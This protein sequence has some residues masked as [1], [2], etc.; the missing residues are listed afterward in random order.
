MEENIHIIYIMGYGRSGSTFLDILFNNHSKIVS[1][2]ALFNFYEWDIRGET[3]A[4][5]NKPFGECEFW[6]KVKTEYYQK[7][8]EKD[9][10]KLLDLDLS[11]ESLKGLSP[12]LQNKLPNSMVKAYSTSVTA[13]FEAISYNSQKKIIVDSSKSAPRAVIGRAYALQKFTP[14]NIKTIHLIRDGRGV[15]WSAMKKSGSPERK[16]N[17]SLKSII[18][19]KTLVNWMFTNTLTLF[20]SRYLNGDSVLLIRYEDLVLTPQAA[21]QQ[22]GGFLG[23]DMTE[24]IQKIESKAPLDVGYN[25]GGNRLR[26]EKGINLKPD[27]EW[28]QKLPRLY[29]LIFWL[30]AWPLARRFGYKFVW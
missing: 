14:F 26:F 3:C 7:M 24:V 21:L 2:G 13:L 15:M 8:E 29:K 20:V 25:L 23:Y 12:L 4:H 19:I 11:V 5:C 10:E 9:P 22:I 30:T 27:F 17:K 16:A 28:T 18:G 6:K 1:V